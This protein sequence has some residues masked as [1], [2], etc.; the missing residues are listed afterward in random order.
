MVSRVEAGTHYGTVF[1][2]SFCDYWC[3]VFV[4]FFSLWWW[5]FVLNFLLLFVFLLFAVAFICLFAYRMMSICRC[6]ICDFA[7]L[8]ELESFNICRCVFSRS[9]SPLFFVGY[10]LVRITT[11]ECISTYQHRHNCRCIKVRVWARGTHLI[12]IHTLWRLLASAAGE[13]LMWGRGFLRGV[14]LQLTCIG[15]T[16]WHDDI[17]TYKIFIADRLATISMGN[18]AWK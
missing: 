16:A 6:R 18:V 2:C 4:F 1:C 15:C 9:L 11:R 8:L 13:G 17:A 5:R 12:Y 10:L 7:I 14:C 3:S